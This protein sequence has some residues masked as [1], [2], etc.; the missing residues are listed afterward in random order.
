LLGPALFLMGGIRPFSLCDWWRRGSS[1][2]LMLK[3]KFQMFYLALFY[4]RCE[5]AFWY[6]TTHS[7]Y[8]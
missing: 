5:I 4:N 7:S 3:N 6:I 8:T 2:L 1:V